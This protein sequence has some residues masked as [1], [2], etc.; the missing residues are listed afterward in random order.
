MSRYWDQAH[1]AMRVAEAVREAWEEVGVPPASVRML[2]SLDAVWI[3]VSNFQLR[4]FVGALDARPDATLCYPAAVDIDEPPHRS[5]IIAL[6]LANL[7]MLAGY[8]GFITTYAPLATERL[9]WTTVD[10]GLA[11]SCFGAGSILLGPPLSHAPDGHQGLLVCGI[12]V[13]GLGGQGGD[14]TT[15]SSIAGSG[16]VGPTTSA[17]PTSTGVGGAP[18]SRCYEWIEA[19]LIGRQ[20]PAADA[21]CGYDP[22]TGTCSPSS[23]CSIMQ[24]LV[25]C[26]C[27]ECAFVCGDTCFDLT[28][29]NDD[30][31]TCSVEAI[32]GACTQAFNACTADV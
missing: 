13:D 10:V 15:T 4:P 28:D 30:C 20:A 3:P 21:M 6:L 1:V 32:G 23:S 9:G 27:G 16:G 31:G 24:R 2:G 17:G 26:M 19:Q 12:D 25:D 18:C 14:V 22:S 8:G 29:P 5:G 7:A 11:F